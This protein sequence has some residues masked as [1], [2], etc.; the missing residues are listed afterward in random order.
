MTPA[1]PEI[2]LT[3][4][5]R[6]L[7]AALALCAGLAGASVAQD[8]DEASRL[9]ASGQAQAALRMVEDVLARQPR[10]AQWRFLR[11]VILAS[12]NRTQDAVT[13]FTQLS[14]DYPELPEPYNN[15]AVLYAGQGEFEKARTALEMAVRTNPA[16][17]TAYENLGDVYIQLA[18]QAYM[19]AQQ[20]D[21]SS[22]SVAPKLKLVRELVASASGAPA[23][24]AQAAPRTAE[25]P[26][27]AAAPTAA[28]E[29]PQREARAA[30]PSTAT[31]TAPSSP[32]FQATSPDS[33]REVTAFVGDWAQ[34]W[35]RQDVEAYLRAYASDFRLPAGRS[36]AT[37]E[38]ERRRLITNKSRIRVTLAQMTVDVEGNRATAR[39]EQTYESPEYQSVTRKTLA[40]V[41]TSD[42]WRIRQE[43]ATP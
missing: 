29:A 4:R 39:F 12:L 18:G 43:T 7:L 14:E 5:A 37:W 42:G 25:R 2:V 20:A 32:S 30:A 38:R 21:A 9:L 13:V 28:R 33:V 8:L 36:R 11:G 40:L 41:R 31:P 24:Q 10:D 1:R 6:R 15:V 16:Y 19:R 35:S 23:S 17:A 3:L 22:R 26:G 34:A 27:S